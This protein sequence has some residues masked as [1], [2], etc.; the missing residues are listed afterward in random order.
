MIEDYTAVE[1]KKFSG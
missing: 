1:K